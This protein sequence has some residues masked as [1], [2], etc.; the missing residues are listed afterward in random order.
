MAT[1]TTRVQGDSPKG[2]P[3]TNA[4]V[5]NNFI[6]LNTAKYESGDAISVANI[7]S[8]GVLEISSSNDV[9]IRLNSTDNSSKLSLS[10]SSG[11]VG[12]SGYAG[13]IR[14]FVGGDASTYTNQVYA[15]Q[16]ST[17]STQFNPNQYDTDFV[18]YYDAG[19][20][21]FV[22]GETGRVGLGSSSP[23]NVLE[24]GSA[25]ANR[26]ISWGHTSAN[27]TNIWAK[28]S[29][30][31]LV[32]GTGIAPVGNSTGYGVSFESTNLGHSAVEI[33]AF[34]NAGSFKFSSK[35]PQNQAVGTS[36]SLLERFR[37]DTSGFVINEPA[38]D[39]DFRVETANFS[40]TLFVESSSAYVGIRTSTPDYALDVNGTIRSS[41][42]VAT[43][44]GSMGFD[45]ANTG[46]YFLFAE[47]EKVGEEIKIQGRFIMDR[48]TGSSFP[49]AGY[50]DV[51]I[52]DTTS[53]NPAI[54]YSP[55]AGGWTGSEDTFTLAKVT[56]DGTKYWAFSVPSGTA[57]HANGV[58]FEGY[59]RRG[60]LL[61]NS[62]D[63]DKDADDPSLT[64]NSEVSPAKFIRDDNTTFHKGP[65]WFKNTVNL[66]SNPSNAGVLNIYDT[67]STAY[68]MKITSSGTRGYK[69]EG[70]SSSGDYSLNMVNAGTGAFN[71]L[72]DGNMTVNNNG[73]AY[74]F[75]VETPSYANA[76]LVDGS[77]NKVFINAKYSEIAGGFTVNN[78]SG[79]TGHLQFQTAQNHS[80]NDF[81]RANIVMSR[82]KD[83]IYWD[84]ST[85]EWVHAGGSSTD[86]TMLSHSA[87][88]FRLFHGGSQSTETRFTNAGFKTDY[89][90]MMVQNSTGWRFDAPQGGGFIFNDRE[91]DRNFQL[92]SDSHAHAFFLDAGD[93]KIG[94]WNSAP[95][96]GLDVL[97]TGRFQNTLYLGNAS[98]GAGDLQVFDTGNNA[99][100]LAGIGSNAFRFDMVGTSAL[101]YI[102]F[103]DF[104]INIK[105]GELT[106]KSDVSG[107]EPSLKGHIRVKNAGGETAAGGLEFH[108]SS[109]GGAGY[110]ARITSDTAGRMFT[111]TRKNA[112]SWTTQTTIDSDPGTFEVEG[113]DT[114]SSQ[115]NHAP[116]FATKLW[117]NV[118]LNGASQTLTTAT[119]ANRTV[120]VYRLQNTA[121]NHWNY[122]RYDGLAFNSD[123]LVPGSANYV[124]FEFYAKN[125]GGT[126]TSFS[127]F[128]AEGDYWVGAPSRTAGAGSVYTTS[129][130]WT[131][132]RSMML[133]QDAYR[134]NF[135]MGFDYNRQGADMLFAFPSI[136][137]VSGKKG[138]QQAGFPIA[139]DPALGRLMIGRDSL[140]V[141]PGKQ[142][143][144]SIAGKQFSLNNNNWTT[145][146]KLY[147]AQGTPLHLKVLSGHNSSGYYG[148]FTND[149]YAYNIADGTTVTLG[150]NG[151]TS[152]YSVQIR[153]IH[154]TGGDDYNSGD[155][156]WEYQIARNQGYGTTVWIQI[157]GV[158]SSWKW[159]V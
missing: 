153:K 57:Y 106:V 159:T 110:G 44:I 54:W 48:G 73:E 115:Y 102:D 138:G 35:P 119:F 12:I 146:G 43:V 157:M 1:I 81:V 111:Q 80:A 118:A 38:E 23:A 6:N 5:D 158:T 141:H 11:S 150:N 128:C 9:G 97:N 117:S 19:S 107:N 109:G 68:T 51:L 127:G 133:M 122:L 124:V 4:E 85:D 147:G 28:Y 47:R 24:L 18:V 52:D 135:G 94:M 142:L 13:K 64:V 149:T 72:V 132:Y 123:K 63:N 20:A 148:E 131:L 87:G 137:F 40:H 65:Q 76:L 58:Y 32:L 136:Y 29:N 42:H 71:L 31:N 113:F 14:L 103:Q 45:Y 155:G 151:S 34:S 114:T 120:D 17:A 152:G 70:S 16:L 98:T 105:S 22:D 10:D 156:G 130:G 60:S 36:I 66:G 78:A 108:T 121:S 99:L 8:S 154:R 56:Y 39:Y 143:S 62:S 77:E 3:L 59:V 67:S 129:D 55:E 75:R 25:T 144:G 30:G 82:N 27:Y 104:N 112:A 49:R 90:V 96:Y 7:T 61:P 86:W 140:E 145:F 46:C 79:S 92:K 91:L 21:L 101:G 134:L 100:Q 53:S 41:Y 50:I 88:E 15:A 139:M 89:Q 93:S 69:F 83:Q 2:S 74:D 125:N 126:N 95:T 26:G 84:N 33:G 37:A 116:P